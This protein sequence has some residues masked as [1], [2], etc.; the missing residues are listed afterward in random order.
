ML[1]YPHFWD[2][3]TEA[4]RDSFT[5]QRGIIELGSE[6]KEANSK[7]QILNQ[8]HLPAVF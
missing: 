6:L 3:E 8:F 4:Q 2:V 7:I 1:I 5:C